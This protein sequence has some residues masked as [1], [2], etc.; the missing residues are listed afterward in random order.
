M[1]SEE[2]KA[3]EWLNKKRQEHSLS[4]EELHYLQIIY[5]LIKNKYNINELGRLNNEENR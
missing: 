3:I 2:V 1:K 5:H 4:G